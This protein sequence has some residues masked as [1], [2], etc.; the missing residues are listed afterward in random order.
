MIRFQHSI[1]EYNVSK[2]DRELIK[3]LQKC[4]FVIERDPKFYRKKTLVLRYDNF[5][6]VLSVDLTEFNN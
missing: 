3:F 2:K 5:Y 1:D 6:D 4:K